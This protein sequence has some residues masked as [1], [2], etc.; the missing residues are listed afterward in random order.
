MTTP[1]E[2]DDVTEPR[3]AITLVPS[4]AP[5]EDPELDV[6]TERPEASETLPA[7]PDIPNDKHRDKLPWDVRGWRPGD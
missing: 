3:L 6:P 2:W 7:P 5:A 4:A 1:D